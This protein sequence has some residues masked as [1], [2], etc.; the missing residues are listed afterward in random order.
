MIS[1]S[2]SS[3]SHSAKSSSESLYRSLPKKRRERRGGS[4]RSESSDSP[5]R[6]DYR[7]KKFDDKKKYKR[8]N[9]SSESNSSVEKSRKDRDNYKRKRD[10][11]KGEPRSRDVRIPSPR[12]KSKEKKSKFEEKSKGD[13]GKERKYKF[14][15]PPLECEFR[16]AAQEEN[17]GDINILATILPS[18]QNSTPQEIIEKL[19]MYQTTNKAMLTK[20]DRKIYVGNLPTGIHA[21]AVGSL[22]FGGNQQCVREAENQPGYSELIRLV[23][24]PLMPGSLPMVSFVPKPFKLRANF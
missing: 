20:L 22:A 8:R 16:D 17:Y 6:K 1:P 10:T 14:D 11:Y 23:I 9:T 5:R 12:R 15:S 18:L 7:S 3:D 21:Q 4:F 13:K 19:N 24:P 2:S